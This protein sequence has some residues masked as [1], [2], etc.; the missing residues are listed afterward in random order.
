M[1]FDDCVGL[2]V[3]PCFK[4]SR[5]NDEKRKVKWQNEGNMNINFR[6]FGLPQLNLS[7]S[8]VQT[9]VGLTA[10]ILSITGA[11]V[12]F[13]KPAPDKGRLVAI[14]QDAKTDKAVP[15]ATVEVLTPLDVLITT[16]KPN[17]SGEAH[18]TL[19]EGRYRLRVNHPRYLS[20]VRDIQLISSQ[21]T[22]VRVQLRTGNP[23]GNAVRRVIHH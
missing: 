23:F 6:I 20:E 1:Q 9:L 5:D 16:L 13:F 21:N 7:L 17:Q 15:D 8:R 14:V 18:C 19:G 3:S 4:G 2:R 22:E 10:G 12:A 11:L